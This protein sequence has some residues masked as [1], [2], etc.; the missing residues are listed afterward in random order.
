MFALFKQLM[1]CSLC[2]LDN[3]TS[4]LIMNQRHLFKWI[5]D[6]VYKEVENVIPKIEIVK[7]K[8]LF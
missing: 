6:A 4:N 2:Y 7:K 8:M 1:R 5:E 3:K